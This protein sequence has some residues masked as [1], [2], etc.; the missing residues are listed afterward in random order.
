MLPKFG[1][2]NFTRVCDTI[3]GYFLSLE[4]FLH[5][6][7]FCANVCVFVCACLCV[8]DIEKERASRKREMVTEYKDGTISS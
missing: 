7:L 2:K 5:F 1:L 3:D 4:N 6:Y 8:I